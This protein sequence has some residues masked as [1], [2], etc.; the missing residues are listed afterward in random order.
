LL[1]NGRS[2]LYTR[3]LE[4]RGYSWEGAEIV[5]RHLDTGQDLVVVAGEDAQYVPTGHLVFAAGTTLFA[6][7]FDASAARI[8]G[9]RVPVVEGVRREVWVAGN[10]ATGNYGFTKDGVLVYFTVPWSEHLSFHAIS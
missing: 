6:A 7:P 8:T 5:V 9:A 4:Q 10:T 1:P 3:L 2:V